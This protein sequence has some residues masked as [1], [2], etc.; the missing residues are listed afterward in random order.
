MVDE[1]RKRVRVVVT[2]HVQGVWYRGSMQQE[3]RRLG[4]AGW[5]RNVPDGSV[6]AVVEGPAAGV[7]EILRWCRSGPAGARV[8]DVTRYDEP[9]EGLTDFRIA[10]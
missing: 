7:G 1:G 9:L 3:A 6:E 8:A 4:L 5:V 10:R 2:G